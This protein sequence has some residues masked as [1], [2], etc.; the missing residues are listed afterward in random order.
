M[1]GYW[2]PYPTVVAVSYSTRSPRLR[3]DV[4]AGRVLIEV[5]LEQAD[6][7]EDE[8]AEKDDE[9]QRP[10][11]ILRVARGARAALPAG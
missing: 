4:R 6:E 1:V 3:G 5:E 9:I 2:S 7:L 11:A 8:E 10:D